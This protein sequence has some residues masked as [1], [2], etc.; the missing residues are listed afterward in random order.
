MSEL[1][2][3]QV[4]FCENYL[5]DP[6][7]QTEAARQAGYLDPGKTS[8]YLLDHEDVKAYLARR[9]EEISKRLGISPESVLRELAGIAYFKL[10]DFVDEDADG[11]PILNI[12][13]LKTSPS[14]AAVTE[15]TLTKKPG[16][17]TTVKVKQADK[18]QALLQIAKHL[19]MMTDKVEVSGKLD[20][21]SL[22]ENSFKTIEQTKPLQIEDAEYIEVIE[23]DEPAQV[24]LGDAS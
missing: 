17:I 16:G 19:G 15:V 14:A 10:S 21:L 11:N 20:F 6:S 23:V 2:E 7:N 8:R 1:N 13:K 12:Q 24:T 5:A 9:R 22:I 3:R 18:V 4:L